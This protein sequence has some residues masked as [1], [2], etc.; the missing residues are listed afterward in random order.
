MSAKVLFVDDEPVVLTLGEEA[1]RREPHIE[2]L[3]ATNGE[4][5]LS[6]CSLEHPDLVFLDV[7]MRGKDGW[8]VCQELK[9]NE[10]TRDIKVV[11][12]TAYA[13]QA[14]QETAKALGADGYMTK[15]FSPAALL[16]KTAEMLEV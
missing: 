10:A 1:L 7:R 9:G 3:T 12:L 14:T 15:P 13:Q 16:K 4:D 5:A 2:V 6:L 11:V 8:E